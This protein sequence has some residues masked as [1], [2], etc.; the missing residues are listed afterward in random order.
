MGYAQS[1][2]LVV[3]GLIIGGLGYYNVVENS[4]IWLSFSVIILGAILIIW[5]IWIIPGNKKEEIEN[6]QVV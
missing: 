2:I 5:G 4:N 6:D 1:S 3:I